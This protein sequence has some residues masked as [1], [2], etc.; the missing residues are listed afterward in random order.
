MEKKILLCLVAIG[1]MVCSTAWSSGTSEQDAIDAIE[2]ASDEYIEVL[3]AGD[4]EA[5]ANLQTEDTIKMGPDGPPTTDR[6]SLAAATRAS[7]EAIE[8]VSFVI[9]PEGFSVLRDVAYTWGDHNRWENG[10]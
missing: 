7:P 10:R 4:V 9:N 2:K 8:F 1:L 3:L 5:Y 6:Q